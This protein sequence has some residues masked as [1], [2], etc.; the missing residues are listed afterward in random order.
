MIFGNRNVGE[1]KTKKNNIP[2]YI[3]FHLK[4]EENQPFINLLQS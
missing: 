2:Q 1:R 3:V 4:E